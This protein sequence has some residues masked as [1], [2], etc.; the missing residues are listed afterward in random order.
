MI[1][2]NVE[3]A[4]DLADVA[5]EPASLGV[6]YRRWDTVLALQSRGVKWPAKWENRK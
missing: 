6:N 4:L 1:Y 2:L 5:L 3:R